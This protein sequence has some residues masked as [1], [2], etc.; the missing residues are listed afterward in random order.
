MSLERYLSCDSENAFDKIGRE[1]EKR[2]ICDLVIFAQD[3]KNEKNH[4]KGLDL[5]LKQ[6]P[7]QSSKSPKR[8]FFLN[9]KLFLSQKNKS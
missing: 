2:V 7:I 5:G 4:S 6:G 1:R 8:G 9:S 3:Q